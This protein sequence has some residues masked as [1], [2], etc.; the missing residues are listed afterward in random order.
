MASNMKVYSSSPIFQGRIIS[1]CRSVKQR[2]LRAIPNIELSG[3]V[4]WI[5][6]IG[7]KISSAEQ[8]LILGMSALM[9]QPFIDF[10]NK[11]VDEETRKV[12]VAR[13]IAKI[14]VGTATGF[15]IRKGC[16]KAIE[17]M[18]QPR[19]LNIPKWKTFFTPEDVTKT[20]TEAFKQYR[21]AM[22]TIVALEVMT[23]TNFLIDAPLTKLLTNIIIKKQENYA[24]KVNNQVNNKG[25]VK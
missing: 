15:A 6:K 8:R 19:L 10:Y 24:V 17:A 12:S 7:E 14:I 1:S 13:T 25:D 9:S 20:D 4:D 22:G 16:I 21:N 5:N 18:S 3:N 2:A 11:N 23:F